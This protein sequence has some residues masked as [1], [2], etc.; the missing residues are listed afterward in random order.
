MPENMPPAP[1]DQ[2]LL[3]RITAHARRT[4][5]RV[6]RIEHQGQSIWIKT[7]E[8]PGLRMWLQK[9]NADRAFAAERAA[10]RTL[11]AAKAP[12]PEILCNSP[13]C[14]ATRDS[15][16]SLQYLIQSQHPPESD[17]IAAFASAGRELAKLHGRG[18][19]HGRPAIKDMCWQNQ[20]ITFLD[21]ERYHDKRNTPKGHMQD[22]II[23]V[24]SAYAI[25]GK[26]CPEI[27]AMIAAYRQHDSAGIWQKAARWCGK[28]GWVDL[29]T[30]PV[31]WRKPGRGR[32]FKAI[33]LTLKAFARK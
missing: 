11:Q 23:M 26:N 20:R 33:P 28:M 2:A 21:F 10:L 25:A 5:Q 32:E 30:K 24:F 16:L 31:Q 18:F 9:G 12:V 19:S 3:D 17:R 13:D 6:S 4:D 27:E 7:P 14:I 8:K 1:S 22:L 29:L 15:G